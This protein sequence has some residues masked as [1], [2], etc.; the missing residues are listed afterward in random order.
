VTPLQTLPANLTGWLEYIEG[1]HPK[2]IAMGL[3]RVNVV[4]ARLELSPDFPII[5]VAGTNGKGSS[6][7][8]LERIYHEAGYRVACY[9]SP[10]LLRYNERVRVG[11]QEVVNEA[12]CDAF[13]AVEAARGEILLT[14]FEF[15]TLAAM[16]HFM[17]TEV[18][19]A[20]LEVGLGGR[21]DAVNAF[22]PTCT[23]VT[24]IDLDHMDYLGD[25]RES[26]GFEKAG[27]FRPGIPAICGDINP[28]DSLVS[29]AASIGANLM[30]IQRDFE[31]NSTGNSWSYQQGQ[32]E[33]KH[34][35]LPALI[36]DFQLFNAACVIT[37][38]Q[39]LQQLLPVTVVAMASGLA[40]ATLA[41]RFQRD[42]SHP[43][44]ILDV[45]HNPHAAVALAENLRNSPCNG[46]TL[47]VFAM[48]ADKDIAGVVAAV[49][50]EIDSWYVAGIQHM[51]GASAQQ[52]TE[53]VR[54]QAPDSD[55][56]GFPDIASAYLQA[57]MDASGND[58]IAVFGSFFTVADV[59]R[60]L[61]QNIPLNQDY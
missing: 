54:L 2:S 57:C 24:G 41:G 53:C 52:L 21:L 30:L 3:D 15:G 48:L 12:L 11:C 59:M 18:D 50:T 8:M 25:N 44:L 16:W 42:S 7:A 32:M 19:V 28:P 4:K 47:A 5:I 9:S 22:E 60:V 40:T 35:P 55:I 10:H 31:F 39:A 51:R 45:A 6:C 27:I 26:I 13:S 38:V 56:H 23:I 46:R 61:A 20:I 1:Q 37:A 34:L 29:H 14:Y 36:G 58:R 49:A 43:Q 33:I 17:Q